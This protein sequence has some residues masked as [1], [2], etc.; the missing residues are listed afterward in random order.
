[1]AI[2]ITRLF[3]LLIRRSVDMPRATTVFQQ[4]YAMALHGAVGLAAINTRDFDTELVT[5]GVY[6]QNKWNQLIHFIFVPIIWFSFMIFHCYLPILGVKMELL[7]HQI[8]WG[9]VQLTLYLTFYLPIDQKLL[10]GRGFC[11]ILTVLYFLAC[12]IIRREK[13]NE[14]KQGASGKPK[15]SPSSIKAW[16]VASALQVLSWYMQLHPGHGIF[17]KVKPA[18]IDALGQS[19]GVAPL[20]A[21]YEGVWF[22]GFYTD[23]KM[24]LI[25]KVEEARHLMCSDLSHQ[26]YSPNYAFCM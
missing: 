14:R 1:L 17:E 18:L 6:H 22:A 23:M 7:G 10:G 19:L 9:T 25:H 2:S 24:N 4:I 12:W 5:Y 13:K 3:F 11:V 20:F 21:F 15:G 8:T 26:Y 16:Q